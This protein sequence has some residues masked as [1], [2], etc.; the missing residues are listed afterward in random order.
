MTDDSS[1]TD[2]WPTQRVVRGVPLYEVV[3]DQITE[4]IFAGR[5]PA[6]FALPNEV[7]LAERFGVA[8]GTL[9][10][11]LDDLTREGLLAR[12]RKTGTVVTGRPPQIS[13]RFLLRYFRLHS[14]DG[15]LLQA[16]VQPP[17]VSL[18]EASEAEVAALSLSPGEEVLR[19][20]RLRTVGGLPVMTDLYVIPVARFPALPRTAEDM[21][22]L[23]YGYLVETGG[24]KISALREKLAAVAASPE[25]AE[26]LGL[27]PGAPVLLIEATV[28]DQNNRPVITA[29]HHANTAQHR[30][31]NE[32][33]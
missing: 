17:R 19:I 5:W 32:L 12:R 13:L 33:Q 30:Y 16:E 24:L 29:L 1:D 9:R 6:G 23:I 14:L 28:Y 27:E 2:L 3:K 8:V 22:G 7:D 25:I 15:G 4:A 20:A 26:E 21:P 10:R 11:A 31:V 18:G